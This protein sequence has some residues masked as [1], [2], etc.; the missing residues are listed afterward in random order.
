MKITNM[1]CMA[2]FCLVSTGCITQETSSASLDEIDAQISRHEVKQN[3]YEEKTKLTPERLEELKILRKDYFLECLRQLGYS[4]LD[5]LTLSPE[6]YPYVVKSMMRKCEHKIKPIY[7]LLI[8]YGWYPYLAEAY[9][10]G[11]KELAESEL[12]IS[13]MKLKREKAK[14][15]V[16]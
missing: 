15:S 11:F 12:P 4:G 2:V 7:D 1:F 10:D 8:S 9:C 13:I 3:D 14:G 6:E 16:L 5:V